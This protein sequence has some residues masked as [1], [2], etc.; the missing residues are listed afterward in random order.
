MAS[1]LKEQ[2]E[3]V[4]LE[5]STWPAWR[6]TEIAAEVA[7]TPLRRQPEGNQGT[8]K[9]NEVGGTSGASNV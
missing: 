1:E 2:L 4:R 8:G 5:T 6:K 7:K 3:A 9:S